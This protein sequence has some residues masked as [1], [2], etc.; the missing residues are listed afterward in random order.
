MKQALVALF[1]SVLTLAGCGD[2]TMMEPP[3]PPAADTA[4][5]RVL[6]LSPDAPAVDAFANGT[7]K[8]VTNLSFPSG[9]DVIKAPVGS[10]DLQVSATGKPASEKVVELKGVTLEKDKSYTVYAFGKLAALQLNA[11][12]ND[13]KGLS[14]SNVRVRVVHAAD[15]V[16]TVNV[17]QL[18]A[19]GAPVPIAENLRYGTAAMPADLPSEPFT[20]G[21]DVNADRTPDLSFAVPALPKGTIVNVFAV[22]DASGSPFLLAQLGG[23]VTARLDPE[24]AQLRVLH[25]SPNAPTVKAF[26]DGQA[27]S[28]W[29][30]VS[31]TQATPFA[32]FSAGMHKLDVG[33]SASMPV[34]T[35]NG[36]TFSGGAKYTAV[37]IGNVSSLKA[38]F[39]ENGAANLDSGKIRIRAI[40]AAPAVGTVD[41]FTLGANGMAMPLL[42]DVPYSGV[43]DPLDVPAGAYTVGVDTNNDA[44]PELWFELPMLPGGTVANVYVTQDST[45]S[46]FALAQLQ[47]GPTV[48]IEKA[49]SKVRVIHLSRNAPAV[50]VYA[51]G[52]KVVTNL[53]YAA[54][55][56]TLTVPSGAYNFAVTATGAAIGTAVINANGVKLLPGKAYTVA[57]YADLANITARVLE[58]DMTGINAT[59]DIRLNVVHVA[60]TVTRGDL[61]AVRAAG[62][63]LLAPNIGFG[64]SARLADLAS[65][66]YRVGF[67]AEANGTI[68]I[69]F[70][71]PVLAPGSFANVFVATDAMGEVYLLVQT[72]SAGTL[73]VNASAM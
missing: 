7:T 17:F 67:D 14:T 28:S 59:T 61:Y 58:D 47:D 48:R 72:M 50:D 9:T 13:T 45:G 8:I 70:N 16:G 43:S 62:N 32:T 1:V 68:D 4:N 15:G 33:T 41:L 54:S 73:R 26:V 55:T 44:N 5:V 35:A 2:G 25:L 18:P 23:S 20:V 22:L 71:L 51:N 3:N 57:A 11:L 6:H 69:A 19:T 36:L 60:P 52:T 53:A 37:A 39:F 40:H 10:A 31:F 56:A 12:E 24:Q 27:P 30:D 64:D 66:S 29:G 65:S 49:T 34:L 38:L 63:L 46:V 21:L 42:N